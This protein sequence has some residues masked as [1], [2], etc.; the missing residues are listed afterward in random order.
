MGPAIVPAIIANSQEELNKMLDL[1]RGKV[2]RVQL[3]FMDGKFVDNT[4]LDFDFTVSADFEYEAHL[5]VNDPLDWVEKNGDKVDIA[6]MQVEAL[7]DIG[8]AVR[9]VKDKGLKVALALN[10]ETELDTILPHLNE[11]DHVLIMTVH[12]G[13][14]CVEFLPETI[15]K[16]KKLREIDEKIPIE[17]D[18]CMDQ[19]HVKIARDAGANIFAIGSY[20]M[21]SDDPGAR[22]N[23][24]KDAASH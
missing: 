14:Y 5:M 6:I 16:I 2:K 7:D 11:L 9:Q 1:L 4:S 12:P 22:I 8:K 24:L 23:E 13:S 10:P 21:K 19:E 15:E 17:V 18:G 3:D 20:I